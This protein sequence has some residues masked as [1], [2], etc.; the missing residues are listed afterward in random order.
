[1]AMDNAQYD[2]VTQ[3]VRAWSPG[4]LPSDTV[5]NRDEPGRS[6]LLERTTERQNPLPWQ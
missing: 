1:M 6:Q 3:G 5:S 2:W 4:N